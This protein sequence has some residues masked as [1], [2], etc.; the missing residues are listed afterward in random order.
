MQHLL[1]AAFVA[2]IIH[3]KCRDAYDFFSY[4]QSSFMQSYS[5]ALNKRLFSAPVHAGHSYVLL[6]ELLTSDTVY[7]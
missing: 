5:V 3:C 6:P 4:G 2:L 7:S 1:S